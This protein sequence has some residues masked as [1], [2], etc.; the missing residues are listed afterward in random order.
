MEQYKIFQPIMLNVYKFILTIAFL[1]LVNKLIISN[2]H[3]TILGYPNKETN[4]VIP[5]AVT[6]SWRNYC[7]NNKLYI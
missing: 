5:K 4:S 2:E 7:P 3:D 1:F 6:F